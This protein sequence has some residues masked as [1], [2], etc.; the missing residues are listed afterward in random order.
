MQYVLHFPQGEKYVSVVKQADTAEAQAVLESERSRLRGL[1]AQQLT[2]AAMLAEPDEGNSLRAA[3]AHAPP[4]SMP[5]AIVAK[6]DMAS[7]M[8]LA[9]RDC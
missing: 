6:C 3:W 1:I 4:V 2:E 5:C 7:C 9:G 8:C